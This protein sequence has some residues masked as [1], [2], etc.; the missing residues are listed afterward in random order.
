MLSQVDFRGG[1]WKLIAKLDDRYRRKAK[2]D[3]L[4]R[5]TIIT[6]TQSQQPHHYQPTTPDKDDQFSKRNTPTHPINPQ[7]LSIL[8]PP[9][10]SLAFTAASAPPLCSAKKK[11]QKR[12][13]SYKHLVISLATLPT[14]TGTKKVYYMEGRG[15]GTATLTS[16]STLVTTQLRCLGVV[17]IRC[18]VFGGWRS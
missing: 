13:I 2:D 11:A 9:S 1:N 3:T 5:A 15:R 4:S 17:V 7:P 18:V 14:I 10:S 6:Q 12:R 8:L 16:L